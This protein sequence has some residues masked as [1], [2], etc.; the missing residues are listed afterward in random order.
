MERDPTGHPPAPPQ[1]D[2]PGADRVHGA[3]AARGVPPWWSN[4]AVGAAA[5]AAALGALALT[6]LLLHPLLLLFAAVV[7]AE[8]L[9]PVVEWI[10]RRLPRAAAVAL[11]Y[12]VLVLVG[13]GLAW[14]AVP[15]L[16]AQGRQLI[17][18][19]PSL[20]ARA[21]NLAE[22][23]DPTSTDQ[24][25][26]AIQTRVDRF[27]LSLIALPL[28]VASVVVEVALVLLLSAYWLIAE[29]A[30]HRFA[31]SLLPPRRRASGGRL[32]GEIGQTVGG[33]VRG[34]GLSLLVV[35]LGVYA[36]LRLIGVEFP[37]LLALIAAFAELIPV[38]G[39]VLATV[40]AVAVALLESPT[41]AA[42]VLVFYVVFQQIE[43]NLLL[44]FFVRRQTGIPPLLAVFALVAGEALAGILGALIAI[45]LAGVARI[46]VVRIVA[47]AIRRRV[48]AADDGA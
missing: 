21:R 7:I 4:A 26:G 24:I 25:L 35:G 13:V 18:A 2:R 32:L 5:L 40:P 48:G 38:V 39:I 3:L 15:T 1:P 44:P 30:L 28:T 29:P 6:W 31:L 37:L 45:P 42:A 9:S 23:L 43:S 34:K 46:L 8:A 11:V 20:L 27:G 47:P 17:A 10:A 33:Y 22:G 12:F 16:V 14:L 41:Q 19:A 36:G